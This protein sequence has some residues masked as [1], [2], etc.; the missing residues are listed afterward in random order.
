MLLRRI[1]EFTYGEVQQFLTAHYRE[2]HYRI[3]FMEALAL[4]NA[5]MTPHEHVERPNFLFWDCVHEEDLVKLT[6]RIPVPAIGSAAHSRK[7]RTLEKDRE[8]RPE[9][10]QLLDVSILKE[11]YHSSLKMHH[12]GGY[13]LVFVLK[14]TCTVKF[15]ADTVELKEHQGCLISPLALHTQKLDEHDIV[16][17][18]C[19]KP[20][21]AQEKLPALMSKDFLLAEFLRKTMYGKRDCHFCF[22][23]GNPRGV[24]ECYRGLFYAHYESAFS[25]ESMLLYL[26]LLLLEFQRAMVSEQIIYHRVERR[27]ERDIMPD[28]IA[29]MRE[30]C[31]EV[32][33]DDLARIFSYEKT[34]LSRRI[35][36]HTG[37]TYSE[38]I[39]KYRIERAKALVRFSEYG[40]EEIGC[41]VGYNSRNS[42]S[43]AFRDETGY[44]PRQYRSQNSKN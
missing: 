44:S 39:R 31:A 2:H 28:L 14:G 1:M 17:T 41:L 15:E 21:V 33:L 18:V 24:Y 29:Y 40:L 43:K 32:S 11:T 30:H 7:W 20:S 12:E 13:K 5:H 27:S 16:V 23:I 25:Q 3:S 19:F 6:D 22:E 8:G 36:V 35:K 42:F 10:E 26:N 4:M 34:Y 9:I 38:L 37:H